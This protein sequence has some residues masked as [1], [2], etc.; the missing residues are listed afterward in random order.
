MT[1]VILGASNNPDRYSY[2]ALIMLREHGHEVIPVHPN[3]REIESI[4]VVSNLR[5][6]DTPVDTLTIYLRSELSEPLSTEMI[7]LAPRRVIFNPGSE[8]AGLEQKL[9]A[10]GIATENAC[11]L[12]LLQSG[13]F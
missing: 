3:L 6:I 5:E 7:Q 11:S 2:R 10:E 1:T 8:S 13:Q 12:V 9:N 4:P